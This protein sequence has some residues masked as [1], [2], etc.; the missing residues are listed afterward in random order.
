M[1]F[2]E[3]FD[4]LHRG[5][6]SVRSKAKEAIQKSGDLLHHL[7]MVAD[8]MNIINHFARAFP[9][10]SDDQLIIQLLGIR[11]F[12]SM[13]GA[14]QNL[15]AGYYQ[16][17]VMQMRD[18]LEVSF[19][20]DYFRTDTA[21]IATW[22]GCS[23]SERNRLFSAFKVRTTLDNRDGFTEKKRMEHYQLLCN[24]GAHASFQGF[25]LLRPRLIPLTQVRLYVVAGSHWVAPHFSSDCRV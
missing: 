17:A 4:L 5:E 7:N 1:I 3:N 15:M 13:S 21:L 18:I 23:E 9:H 2:P 19:L 16:N 14:V 8:S 6:E 24:L 12:N 22:K 25:E 10:K 11:L 20:S